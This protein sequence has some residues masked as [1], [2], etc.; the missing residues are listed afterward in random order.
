MHYGGI[1]FFHEFFRAL[2][3]WFFL[4]R[5]SDDF[6][7]RCGYTLSQ[8]LLCLVHLVML[9]FEHL[10]TVALLQNHEIFQYLTGMPGPCGVS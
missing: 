6:K 4:A 10:E 8:L 3:L 2:Q 7:V 1:V 5:H 9:G